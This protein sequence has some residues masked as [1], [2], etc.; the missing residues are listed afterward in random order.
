MQLD[1]SRALSIFIDNF[2]IFLNGILN[3][4][5]FAIV[6]TVF[7]L[8]IGLVLG[9]IKAIKIEE[10]D[11]LIIKVLKKIG[12]IFTSVY[13]FVLRGTPMMIQAVFFY[14]LLRDLVHWDMFT[15][16]LYI[17]SANTGAYM[18]EII[19]SGIQSTDI[20]QTEAAKSLGFGNMQT[21]FYI[22][23]P[24]AIKNSFP[25]IGNQLIVNIKDSS[26]LNVLSI[27]ELF[28]QSMSIAG[29][30]YSYVE[31]YFI[32][33]ILYLI[34]TSIAYIALNYFENKLNDTKVNKHMDM[35][36]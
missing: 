6:G 21:L 2:D 19:R 7:G 32:S 11:T 5:L 9:G 1:L 22:I 23:L 33:A 12:H 20:G 14:Y 34:L 28:F 4:I 29:S 25:S 31:T 3:T 18:A 10:S 13:I 15:A 16:G 17:I 35:C 8:L 26:M 30:N 27:T 24:Q 36:A